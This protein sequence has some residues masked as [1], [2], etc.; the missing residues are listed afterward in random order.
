MR[1]TTN[2]EKNMEN[3]S[4]V[5]AVSIGENHEGG[6]ID[7]IFASLARARS[8]CRDH[9]I[10]NSGGWSEIDFCDWSDG[11]NFMIIEKI[12]VEA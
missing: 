1:N 9:K 12:K 10:L 8:Y 11:C 6:R 3:N 7:K 2:E 5:F 4:A